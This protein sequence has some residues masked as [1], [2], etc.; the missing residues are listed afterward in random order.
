MFQS[1]NMTQNFATKYGGYFH[2]PRMQKAPHKR[3][4]YSFGW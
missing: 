2:R 1:L 4:I 3:G